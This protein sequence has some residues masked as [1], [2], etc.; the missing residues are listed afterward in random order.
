M[1]NR[2]MS[3]LPRWHGRPGQLETFARHAVELTNDKYGQILYLKV[4]ESSIGLK[5]AEPKQFKDTLFL[6]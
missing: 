2:A 4:A 3:L 1:K 5:D 6:L